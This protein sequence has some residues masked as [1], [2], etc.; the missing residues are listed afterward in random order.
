MITRA[1][2]LWDELA[3]LHTTTSTQAILNLKQELD[4]LVFD[5]KKN[6]VVHVNTF[7]A[8]CDELSSYG[9]EIDA[10]EKSSKL[11]RSLP[12]SLSELAMVTQHSAKLREL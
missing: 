1:K 9:E 6:F 2:E 8:I 4:S 7:V 5:E 11:M 12:P 3:R 10:K